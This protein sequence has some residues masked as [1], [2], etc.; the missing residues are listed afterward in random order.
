MDSSPSDLPLTKLQQVL[1]DTFHGY[2]E[3]PMVQEWMQNKIPGSVKM[4]IGM[5][6]GFNIQTA[7]DYIDTA[8]KK[9]GKAV[10]TAVVFAKDFLTR[11]YDETREQ[12]TEGVNTSASPTQAST[13]GS[14][15]GQDGRGKVDVSAISDEEV[16]GGISNDADSDHRQQTELPST[17]AP[18]RSVSEDDIQERGVSGTDSK[19]LSASAEEP[20]TR[21]ETDALDGRESSDSTDSGTA[22]TDIPETS[23]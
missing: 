3:H 23:N 17:V 16:A 12:S 22:S 8:I 20:E 11:I 15:S 1:L 10:E 6:P 4:V 2:I 13:E 5:I 7:I 21:N 19:Q 18:E 14:D 9:D